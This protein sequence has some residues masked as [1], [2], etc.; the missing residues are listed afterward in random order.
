MPEVQNNNDDWNYK[1]K[2]QCHKQNI[3][4]LSVWHNYISLENAVSFRSNNPSSD[5]VF[6]LMMDYLIWNI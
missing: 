4:I 5:C 1:S 3:I 2:K 6:S